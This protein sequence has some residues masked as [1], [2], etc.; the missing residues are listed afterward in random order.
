MLTEKKCLKSAYALLNKICIIDYL[1]PEDYQHLENAKK[2]L[3]LII[4]TIQIPD[5]KTLLYLKRE[6][7]SVRGHLKYINDMVFG[8]P[9]YELF[10]YAYQIIDTI[11]T[12]IEESEE[13]EIELIEL[14]NKELI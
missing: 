2:E 4:E 12:E 11:I 14:N 9:T 3:L 8:E 10:I 1:F 13:I 7:K 5:V 6:L